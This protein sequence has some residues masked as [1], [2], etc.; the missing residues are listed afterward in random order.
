M[1][2]ENVYEPTER[3]VLKNNVDIVEKQKEKTVDTEE[4]NDEE[5]EADELMQLIQEN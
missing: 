4:E 5:E 3:F 1:E 2:N